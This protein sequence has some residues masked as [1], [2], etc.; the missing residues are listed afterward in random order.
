M[1][2]RMQPVLTDEYTVWLE[3]SVAAGQ[4]L[5]QLILDIAARAGTP[6]FKPHVTLLPGLRGEEQTLAALTR[7]LAGAGACPIFFTGAQTGEA[8]HKCLYLECEPSP[9]LLALRRRGEELS[10]LSSQFHPH[11]SLAYGLSGEPLKQE[12][13][14]L[15]GRTFDFTAERISLWHAKGSV[16]EWR[17]VAGFAL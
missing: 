3:P 6:V 5:Q 15:A 11:M 13:A 2:H 4:E 17:E 16:E 12:L 8:Y 9:A 14:A 1:I 7:N 10:G